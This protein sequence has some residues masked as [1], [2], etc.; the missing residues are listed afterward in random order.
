[1][2]LLIELL[3]PN[4]RNCNCVVELNI[5]P[6][7][8]Q[9][10]EIRRRKLSADKENKALKCQE[11]VFFNNSIFL[12]KTLQKVSYVDFIYFFLYSFDRE[13]ARLVRVL[14]AWRRVQ[15]HPHLSQSL[16]HSASGASTDTQS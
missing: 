12:L 14:T 2:C 3:Q 11:S 6:S 8:S 13:Y 16:S 7:F 15:N 5:S 4:G 10:W 1:M 9:P